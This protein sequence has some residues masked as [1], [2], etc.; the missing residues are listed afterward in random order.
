[1]SACA[2]DGEHQLPRD[3]E[4]LRDALEAPREARLEAPGGRQ[5]LG[6]VEGRAREAGERRRQQ[7][8]RG[9]AGLRACAALGGGAALAGGPA[10]GGSP[11]P[12][13]AGA[14]SF[15]VAVPAT[16]LVVRV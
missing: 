15:G 3:A 5:R 16:V 1:V 6:G 7:G 2:A 12:H 10:L 4:T 13:G 8:L 14:L 9:A 11:A